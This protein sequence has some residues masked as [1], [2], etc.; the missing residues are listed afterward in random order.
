MSI[1]ASPIAAPRMEPLTVVDKRSLNHAELCHELAL[2]SRAVARACADYLVHA[3]TVVDAQTTSE[4]ESHHDPV[5]VFDREVETAVSQMLA[6]LVPGCMKLGEE[7]GEETLIPQSSEPSLPDGISMPAIEPH[8]DVRSLG[9]RVRWIVDPIDGTSNF[10]A[11]LTDFN[12]SIAAELDGEVVAGA[13]HVPCACETFWGNDHAGWLESSQGF[14]ALDSSGPSR[15]E[16]AI[17]LTYFPLVSELERYPQDALQVLSELSQAFRAV[18]RPGAAALDL[19]H[20]AAGRAGAFFATAL[21]P[22]DIAAGAHLLRV[23][24]GAVID[25]PLDTD[26]PPGFGPAVAASAKGLDAPTLP[27]ALKL[28][29]RARRASSSPAA[30]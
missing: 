13:V 4:K 9:S 19:A 30:Q 17:L 8:I 3:R 20:I 28:V 25:A 26:T 6:H 2:I 22:W 12:T 11:G 24:G 14:F 7:H 23:A 1:E 29:E 18:R 21:K 5:T 10:A 16:D 15:E 27:R